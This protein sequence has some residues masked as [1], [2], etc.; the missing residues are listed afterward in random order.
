MEVDNMQSDS[1]TTVETT[2]ELNESQHMEE[3]PKSI[4]IGGLDILGL[5]QACKTK[6]L[7]KILDQ[8]LE[9][10]EEILSRAQRKKSLGIQTRGLSEVDRDEDF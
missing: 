4:D 3:E 2:E 1:R 9:N 7:D 6:Y 10:L 5:K 8:Q